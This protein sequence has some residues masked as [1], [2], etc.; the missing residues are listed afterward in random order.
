MKSYTLICFF[1]SLA[2]ILCPLFSVKK[3]TDVIS[4]EL[5][6]TESEEYREEK[7][8]LK[9]ETDMVKVMNA[10]TNNITEITIRDYLLGVVAEEINPAYHKEAIKAQIIASHTLLLYIKESGKDKP[11]NAHITDD[12]TIHQGYLTESQQKEKWGENYTDYRNK[13]E[14]CID[15]VGHLTLMYDGEI[16]NSVYHALSNGRTQSAKEVWGGDYPYLVSVVSA[17]DALS[18]AFIS[19]VELSREDF[20]DKMNTVGIGLTDSPEKWIGKIKSFESGAV[21]SIEIGGK[22]FTGREIRSCF[23]LKSSTFT[24]SYDDDVFTFTVKGYGHG[25]GMSQYGANHMAQ[26]GFTYEEIL[27]HYYKEVEIV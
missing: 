6:A 1:L 11:E 18:P 19:K 17:G 27:K 9:T 2:M 10:S 14:E 5:F 23:N 13:I 24:I 3:A 12:S 7:T 22:E 4:R 26:Q 25:V 21:E 16:A 20:A 15:E 8:T